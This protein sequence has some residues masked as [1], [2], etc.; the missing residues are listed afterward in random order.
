MKNK[1]Q[2]SNPARL[3]F[4]F[5]Q[6][7]KSY[8]GM[9]LLPV[10]MFGFAIVAGSIKG[11][12]IGMS[13]GLGILLAVVSLPMASAQT[14]RKLQD[15]NL[16]PAVV[17]STAP[18][19]VAVLTD[20]CNDGSSRKLALKIQKA[21]LQKMAGGPPKL[22]QQLTAVSVYFGETGTG[23]W[24]DFN[25]IVANCACTNI[26]QLKRALTSIERNDWA[27]LTQAMKSLK[28]TALGLHHIQA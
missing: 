22:G 12:P 27:V 17:V 20:L 6:Y 23:A 13:V 28:P 18:C 1:S 25:P 2:A 19:T 3:P 5:V 15:G 8:P 11:V 26:E 14:K 21:P 4:S 7:M 10:G 24:A 16:C 9:L